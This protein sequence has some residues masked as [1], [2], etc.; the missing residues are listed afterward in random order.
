MGNSN[1]FRISR[2]LLLLVL[3]MCVRG[4]EA[5]TVTETELDIRRQK[6]RDRGLER[7]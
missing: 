6:V 4:R 1:K 7:E 3:L 2:Y 5:E